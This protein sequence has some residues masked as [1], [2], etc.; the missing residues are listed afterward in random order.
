M[1]VVGAEREDAV[2]IDA[3]LERRGRV[4]GLLVSGGV[5]LN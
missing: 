5:T 4:L 1:W 2:E 3:I